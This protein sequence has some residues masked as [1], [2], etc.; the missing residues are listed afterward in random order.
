MLPK[1]KDGALDDMDEEE[2]DDVATRQQSKEDSED[3]DLEVDLPSA[4]QN[5]FTKLSTRQDELP[6]R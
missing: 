3:E 5:A 4:L 2:E 1:S 6:H